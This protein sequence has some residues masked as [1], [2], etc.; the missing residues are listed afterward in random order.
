MNWTRMGASYPLQVVL[1]VCAGRPTVSAITTAQA[2][3]LSRTWRRVGSVPI[4][5]Y[6][7]TRSLECQVRVGFEQVPRSFVSGEDTV[8]V[9]T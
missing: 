8:S 5:V 2:A 7:D 6:L 3:L 9:P 1:A 4:W